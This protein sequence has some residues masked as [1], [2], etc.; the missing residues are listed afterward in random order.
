VNFHKEL[1][2]IKALKIELILL[3]VAFLLVFLIGFDGMFLRG[4]K[5]FEIKY[6]KLSQKMSFYKSTF[7]KIIRITVFAK[8]FFPAKFFLL[9]KFLFS[10]IPK[11]KKIGGKKYLA[12]FF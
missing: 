6:R 7:H 4:G 12:I 5:I 1:F 2:G 9:I 8:Y 10:K 3:L 11:K